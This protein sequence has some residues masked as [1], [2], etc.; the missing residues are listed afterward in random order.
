MTTNFVDD[1][2][3]DAA[4]WS[5]LRSEAGDTISLVYAGIP[6]RAHVRPLRPGMPWALIVYRGHELED[7]L[8]TVTI[9]LTLFYTLSG[10]IGLGILTGLLLLVVHW[11]TP[12]LIGGI[13]SMIGRAAA[14][15]D[16]HRWRF[17]ALV[18][19]V[20]LL[21]LYG[22]ALA[23]HPGPPG[24]PWLPWNP[25]T[26][27]ESWNPWPAFPV[28]AVCS[29][30]VVVVFLTC[31]VLGLR[32]P[33]GD[34]RYG[35]RTLRR[36]VALA[37]VLAG[38]AVA[39]AWLWFGHHRA[40]LGAALDHY[41]VDRTLESV[42][43]AREE[44]RIGRLTR[45]GM[46]VAPAGDRTRY[47][48]HDEPEPDEGWVL[49]ALRPLIASSRLASDLLVHR[50]LARPAADDVV[51]LH[52]VFRTTFGYDVT[53]PLLQP[54]AGRLWVL[55]L[56]SISL[57]A[58]L[59]G[60][61]A[62]SLCAVCTMVGGRLA[63]VVKLPDANRL[64]ANLDGKGGFE[65][66][67]RAIVLHRGEWDREC[68]V[69][70]LDRHFSV[71][72]LKVSSG[73]YGRP[74]TVGWTTR[75]ATGKTAIYTFDDLEG[76]L[77]QDADGRARFD[78]LQRL[79]D[80]GAAVVLCSRVV[81]DHRYSDRRPVD[82]SVGNREYDVERWSRLAGG[83][84]LYV[85]RPGPE[86]E[87][88][89]KTGLKG[90]QPSPPSRC[91]AEMRSVEQAMKEE[92]VANPPLLESALNVVVDMRRKLEENGCSLE[93]ARAVAV[94]SFRQSAARYFDRLW[95][96]ST[97]DE[98]LQ[99]DALANGGAVDSRRTLVLSSLVNRGLVSE[100]PDS[101]VVSL[102]SEAFRE[103]IRH[104]V[105][106]AELEAWR[107]EGDGGTWRFIWP[108]VA[109]VGGLGLAF[110]AMAN[111]EMRTPLLTTLLGLV[112]AALPVLR[113]GQGGGAPQT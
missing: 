86:C 50:G 23:L 103:H 73:G 107:K 49:A 54:D 80:D 74:R 56:S 79:V 75:G 69:R 26:V 62:Y 77:R 101:A 76:V 52:G 35:A 100:D 37:V 93:D 40:A 10:L 4:L 64:L 30:A 60:V 98:R 92:A 24:S 84:R 58:A 12:R 22:P 44:Y 27:D 82:R 65:Q 61:V 7:R 95:A 9:S 43:Q 97:R 14:T 99:L 105:D 88:H 8:T 18:G 36:V 63:G 34:N 87:K 112:P 2:G 31:C 11:R 70:R 3:G 110:L 55:S 6:I 51:S 20:L 53:W 47:R 17:V 85:L 38:L 16:R 108:T 15:G 111:P 104:D 94:A 39:P 106:H 42:A 72:M 109:V 83:F 5:L 29:A 32:R 78:E 102:S 113:G 41:L 81:P 21:L 45:H 46:T 13:P 67:L 28:F 57:I 89:F 19:V 59:L 33:A 90:L 68:F 25:W 71:Q 91:H 96:D 66:P 1:V 48:V